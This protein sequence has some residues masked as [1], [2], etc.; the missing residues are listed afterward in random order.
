MYQLIGLFLKVKYFKNL[1][2]LL[3]LILLLADWSFIFLFE[4]IALLELILLIISSLISWSKF[5]IVNSE[6]ILSLASSILE[7]EFSSIL[8]PKLKFI[9]SLAINDV[10][11]L[12]L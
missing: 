10:I 2:S 1:E 3:E 6:L 9:S 7:I 11:E 8:L 4:L 12:I 5:K